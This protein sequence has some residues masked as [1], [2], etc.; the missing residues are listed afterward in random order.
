[1]GHLEDGPELSAA[2]HQTSP[3]AHAA[4]PHKA[5]Q[6]QGIYAVLSLRK[7]GLWSCFIHSHLSKYSSPSSS[8]VFKVAFPI[9]NLSSNYQ[10]SESVL[11]DGSWK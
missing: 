11:L 6:V 1:M 7:G 4:L 9:A 10:C 8:S 5:P 3:S 2:L